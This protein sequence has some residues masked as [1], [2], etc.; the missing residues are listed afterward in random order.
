[1][2]LIVKKTRQGKT[3]ARWSRNVSKGRKLIT[4]SKKALRI[5]KWFI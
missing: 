1:M 3:I 5:A 2:N 4:I